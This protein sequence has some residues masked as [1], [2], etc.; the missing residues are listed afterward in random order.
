MIFFPQTQLMYLGFQKLSRFTVPSELQPHTS[1]SWSFHLYVKP[2]L[3]GNCALSQRTYSPDTGEVLR[4]VHPGVCLVFRST[5]SNCHWGVIPMAGVITNS[6]LNC[7]LPSP[8]PVLWLWEAS[9]WLCFHLINLMW[10]ARWTLK[11]K[12][13]IRWKLRKSNQIRAC[14]LINNNVS[15]LVH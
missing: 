15:I 2:F 1:R 3:L 14:F 11:Q 5:F 6:E 7:F 4:S 8:F 12:K 10:Y 13:N 9:L